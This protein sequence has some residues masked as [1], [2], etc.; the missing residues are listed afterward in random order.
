MLFDQKV[1]LLYDYEPLKHEGKL[2]LSNNSSQT[3]EIYCRGSIQSE[4][5]EGF[6]LFHS[7]G[8]YFH[9]N[10]SNTFYTLKCCVPAERHYWVFL[11]EMLSVMK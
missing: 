2:P 11:I 5:L 7:G 9:S 3:V 4:K 10:A 1:H 6:S 8:I